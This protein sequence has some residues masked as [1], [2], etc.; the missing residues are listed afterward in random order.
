LRPARSRP[1]AL[2]VLEALAVGLRVEAAHAQERA[3]AV[4]RRVDQRHLHAARG[5]SV[6]FRK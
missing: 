3:G 5:T 6:S 4:A 2:L 1:P